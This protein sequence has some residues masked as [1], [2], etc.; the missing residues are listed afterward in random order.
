M[1]WLPSASGPLN[2]SLF[3]RK[4]FSYPGLAQPG[5]DMR[6]RGLF[7]AAMMGA[8]ALGSGGAEAAVVLDQ[9][10]NPVSNSISGGAPGTLIGQTF[11][12]GKSGTLDNIRVNFIGTPS[13]DFDLNFH[14][15]RIVGGEAL[16]SQSIALSAPSTESLSFYPFDTDPSHWMKLDLS[17]LNISV[18][19]GDAFALA[20]EPLDSPVATFWSS[21]NNDSYV[22]GYSFA[23]GNLSDQ[24]FTLTP[25]GADLEFATYVSSAVPEPGEWAMLIAGFGLIG[26]AMRRRR[27]GAVIGA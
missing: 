12:V 22:G 4:E 16:F 14:L 9:V 19:A 2:F 8:V 17:A 20:V 21:T 7:L 13:T 26:M 5:D 1:D 23:I 6:T 25:P 11:T 10:N 24:V 3:A 18:Q 27:I 15:A